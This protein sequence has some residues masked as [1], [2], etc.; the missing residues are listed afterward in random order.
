MTMIPLQ[1]GPEGTWTCQPQNQTRTWKDWDS[2][3]RWGQM[4]HS[5]PQEGGSQMPGFIWGLQVQS[6]LG[7]TGWAQQLSRQP[8]PRAFWLPPRR[9]LLEEVQTEPCSQSQ[10][11]HSPRAGMIWGLPTP[12]PCLHIPKTFCFLQKPYCPALVSLETPSLT[13]RRQWSPGWPLPQRAISLLS[14]STHG[15]A[16]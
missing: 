12:V 3:S 9:S 10:H 6:L 1:R 2:P 5:P 14:F 11:L 15:G 7:G 8:S 13:V 16:L 4:P